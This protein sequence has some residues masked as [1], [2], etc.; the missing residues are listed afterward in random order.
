MNERRF[1]TE[2]YLLQAFLAFNSHFEV[3]WAGSYM[4]LRH[5]DRLAAAFASYDAR[6]NWPGS[7]W[8]RKTK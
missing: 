7:F 4:H 1:W 2:Q 3:L 8:M 6:R 5:P